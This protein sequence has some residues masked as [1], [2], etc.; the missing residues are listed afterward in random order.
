MAVIEAKSNILEEIKL[1]DMVVSEGV[2]I[3]G[4]GNICYALNNGVASIEDDDQFVKVEKYSKV[5][6]EI[7]KMNLSFEE[8]IAL[9][10]Y[11][12]SHASRLQDLI[13]ELF[14]AMLGD[15]PAENPEFVKDT[16]LEIVEEAGN[17]E[18]AMEAITLA[19]NK[20][21]TPQMTSIFIDTIVQIMKW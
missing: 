11:M 21:R 5:T 14:K 18:L 16:M 12:K 19:S 3:S 8:V 10:K 1:G 6:G 17:I 15:D 20:D 2:V 9:Y 4:E 7:S 13:K